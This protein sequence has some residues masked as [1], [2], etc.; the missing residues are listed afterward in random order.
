MVP[1]A[2]AKKCEDI[3]CCIQNFQSFFV[4]RCF[5]LN[6]VF[7]EMK[8][9][10]CPWRVICPYFKSVDYF[11]WV[12]VIRAMGWQEGRGKR[13]LLEINFPHFPWWALR[14]KHMHKHRGTGNFQVG[15]LSLIKGHSK[16]GSWEFLETIKTERR[17]HFTKKHIFLAGEELKIKIQKDI[18]NPSSSEW[19]Y[20]L[21]L[22]GRRKGFFL[23]F[24]EL[25]T[26]CKCR[27]HQGNKTL[28][29]TTVKKPHN[30]TSD[31]LHHHE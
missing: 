24:W 21:P 18:G 27:P 25:S 11:L 30:C 12:R 1:G 19:T 4:T 6:R 13:K 28:C 23:S 26:Q 3:L 31:S 9:H 8:V 2:S 17:Q 5:I 15:I 10:A 20:C 14:Y 29:C 16:W 7:Q 22:S